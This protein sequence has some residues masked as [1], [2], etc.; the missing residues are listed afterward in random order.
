MS[1]PFDHCESIYWVFTQLCND[2]CAHCYNDSS[3][4]GARISLEDCLAIVANLPSRVDRLILSGGEPLTELPKLHAILDALAARYAGKTQIML[5]PNGDLLTGEKLDGLLARGVTRVDVASIDR[6]HKHAGA[7]RGQL[8]ELFRSRGMSGDETD[9]LV[10]KDNYV[11][12]G[13]ASYGFWGANEEMWLGGNW[14][15]GQAMKS[16]V[17]LR[18]GEHNF[19][20]ILSG[21][22]GF[23]GGTDL[24][25]EISIQLW[26]INPCCPGTRYP[27]GDARTER[28]ADVLDRVAQSPVFRKIN[29]GNPYAMGETLGISEEQGH[30]RARAL[31]NVCL[32]C[33]EFFERDREADGEG[34]EGGDAGGPRPPASD[35]AF[36][37]LP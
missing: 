14:A 28:V 12:P 19:C 32:W 9:P 7:R 35:P 33:D 1:S 36:R 20:A 3:P 24:P 8:E 13:A 25:Q 16:G 5:Q 15:R 18:D 37:L 29:E 27:M 34:G 22:K 17:W 10:Q 31:G 30:E 6:F 4:T 11:K 21:G 23:L 2:T 26:K